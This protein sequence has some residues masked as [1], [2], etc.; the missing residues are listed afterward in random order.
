MTNSSSARI[1]RTG[2]TRADIGGLIE[3]ALKGLVPMFDVESQLF[4]FRLKQS[5]TK[6]VREGL[7]RRYTIMTLWGFNGA[8]MRA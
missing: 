3:R 2:P 1:V 7:S 6:L 5:G 4:C 8:K